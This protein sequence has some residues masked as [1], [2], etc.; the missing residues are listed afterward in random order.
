MRARSLGLRS[1]GR[2]SPSTGWLGTGWSS[3]GCGSARASWTRGQQAAVMAT[4]LSRSC[5]ELISYQSGA[6]A[7]WQALA[8]PADLGAI[9]ALVRAE[10]WQSLYRGVYAAYTGPPSRETALWAAVRRCGPDAV[11]SHLTAAELVGL[12][13]GQRDVVHVMIP[14]HLR[15]RL[16]GRDRS[17]GLPRIVV[18]RSARLA[19]ARHPARTPPRTRIEENVLDLTELAPTF[20]AAFGWLSAACGR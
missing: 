6:L 20:D 1:G 18:H 17:S 3:T 15:V 12:A 7:R 14:A 11:L 2:K 8:R 13:D 19:L 5:G 4:R 16:S 9:D 10:R